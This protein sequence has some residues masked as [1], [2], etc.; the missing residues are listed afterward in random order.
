MKLLLL[1]AIRLMNRL[2]LVYKFALISILFLLPI[3]ALGYSLVS[4]MYKDIQAVKNEQSGLRVLESATQIYRLALDYRDYRTVSKLRQVPELNDRVEYIRKKL[5]A[6]LENLAALP[7]PFDTRNDLKDQLEGVVKAWK[8]MV[9]EDA[10]QM[11]LA[12]QFNYYDTFVKKS[13]SLVSSVGQLSGLSLDPSR[14]VQ[15][16]LNFNNRL[17]TAAD[18]VG[19]ARAAGIFALV[20]GRVAY[21]TSDVLNALYDELSGVQTGLL[22]ALDVLLGASPEVKAALSGPAEALRGLLPKVRDSMDEQIITPASLEMRWPEFD[23]LASGALKQIYDF[24]SLGL[25]QVNLV[26]ENRLEERYRTLTTIFVV[27]GI[28]LLI[29]IYLYSGFFVSVK[30]T[31][32]RFAQAAEKVANGDLTVQLAMSNRDEMGALSSEF[33]SMTSRMHDLIK[34]VAETGQNVDQQAARVHELAVENREAVATQMS[35]TEQIATSMHQMA[36][37]VEEVARSSEA[38][39]DSAASANDEAANGQK[40]VEETLRTIEH[41]AEEI[42]RSMERINRV[43]EDSENIAQ[44][45]VEIKAIAD[46]TNLLALN[47]AI[48][49]ARAGEQ[50]RGFAVVADE[51]RTLSQRTQKSTEEIEAMIER[52]Q[53][54]VSSA[55]EAMQDS[56]RATQRTVEQSN[57]VAAALGNIVKAVA[58]IVDM[59]HQIAQAAEEQA[60]VAKTIDQNVVR[61]SDLGHETAENAD[62]TLKA[63]EALSELTKRLHDLIGTFRV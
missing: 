34:V 62:E 28:L 13:R 60:V 5:N 6:E 32:E 55:V 49:A 17:H 63:S 59:S 21:E 30:G 41:L 36:M 22:P 47:A 20:E 18:T 12:P 1:P 37:T 61:I 8:Q 40:V 54:G 3:I 50:G 24:E 33:N 57:L 43:E 45:L 52:L 4:Q 56:H 39:A 29:I 42:N 2:K 19:H 53:S 35:E 9:A 25:E 27:Q 23:E 14:T 15:F 48:E 7:M 38:A 58:N 10:N 46:Q 16:I 11:T 44:V 26:L 31:I 51:V